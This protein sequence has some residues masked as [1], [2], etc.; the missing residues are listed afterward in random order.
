MW[1]RPQAAIWSLYPS[2][3]HSHVLGQIKVIDPRAQAGDPGSGARL[4]KGERKELDRENFRTGLSLL[5]TTG[6]Q[7]YQFEWVPGGS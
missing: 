1:P 6:L 3:V 2:A 5:T 7:S 4:G